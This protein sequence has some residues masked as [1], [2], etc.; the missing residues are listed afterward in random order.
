LATNIGEVV[1]MLAAALL[2]LPLPLLPIQLLWINLVG[3]GLPAIA[4][5]NDPPA[6]DIMSQPPRTADESVFSGGLGRKVIVRGVVI[7]G[8]SLLLY[9]WRLTRAGS[10][11]AARTLVLAHLAISQFIHIFDC[12]F[13]K[14]TGKV[15]LLSNRWLIAAVAL[16]M[17][18]VIGVIYLPTLQ[19]MFATA[20]L[21]IGEWLL[22]LVAAGATSIV[23]ISLGRLMTTMSLPARRQP[24][25]ETI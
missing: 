1:L 16:S 13:E 5:V 17:S 2:G 4:L 20:G 6:G 14:E 11:V 18:M 3:D 12:R 9:C 21:G 8:A 24:V 25:I 19:P 23:D 22:A 7:G 10:V 15:E